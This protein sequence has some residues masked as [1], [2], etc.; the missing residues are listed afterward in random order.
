MIL[1]LKF[2]NYGKCEI[3]KPFCTNLNNQKNST[4]NL[5]G[6]SMKRKGNVQLFFFKLEGL[7]GNFLLVL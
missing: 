6:L 2:T 5:H 3:S 7:F 1:S 4:K